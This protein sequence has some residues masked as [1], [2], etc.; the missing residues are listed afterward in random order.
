MTIGI[1]TFLMIAIPFCTFW[2]LYGMVVAACKIIER[3]RKTLDRP[4]TIVFKIEEP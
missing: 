4:E 1:L 3:I 2:I